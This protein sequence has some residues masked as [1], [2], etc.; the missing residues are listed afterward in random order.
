[1]PN[2]ATIYF[3]CVMPET[4]SGWCRI[5]SQGVCVVQDF[6]SLPIYKSGNTRLEASI[7]NLPIKYVYH[8]N[9]VL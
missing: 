3:M 5:F 2:A 7:E 6:H 4:R 9:Q 8:V 1:M